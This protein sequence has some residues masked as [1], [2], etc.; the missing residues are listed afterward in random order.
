M[1]KPDVKGLPQG[2]KGTY[3]DDCSTPER[4]RAMAEENERLQRESQEE[5]IKS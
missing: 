4:R 5:L 3:C 2:I 1:G